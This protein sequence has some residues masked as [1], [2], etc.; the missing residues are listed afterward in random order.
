MTELSDNDDENLS[1]YEKRKLEPVHR[2]RGLINRKTVLTLALVG[3][4]LD[5]SFLLQSKFL[6]D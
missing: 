3:A 6:F 2:S 5:P 1:S 4:I